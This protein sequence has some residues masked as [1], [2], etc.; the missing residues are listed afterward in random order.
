MNTTQGI[1]YRLSGN[2]FQ[3]LQG[4][5]QEALMLRG[6]QVREGIGFPGDIPQQ[7]VEAS[8]FRGLQQPT[9]NLRIL[10]QSLNESEVI[11]EVGRG[12]AIASLKEGTSTLIG[13]AP[14]ST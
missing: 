11:V 13:S 10:P 12:E 1:S 2:V 7:S 6:E 14:A 9:R 8:K 5:Q 4:N 3:T